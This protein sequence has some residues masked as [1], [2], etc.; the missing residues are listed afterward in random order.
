MSN[1]EFDYNN[2]INNLDSQAKEY[3]NNEIKD[4]S[5]R[6]YL[7][8]R[9]NELSTIY[10]KSLISINKADT[11]RIKFLTQLF[12]E[13]LYHTSIDCNKSEIPREHW[14]EIL[15]N[16]SACIFEETKKSIKRNWSYS[17]TLDSV[18]KSLEK[19]WLQIIDKLYNNKKINKDIRD[20]AK[21]QSN[22]KEMRANYLNIQYE[23]SSSIP[24]DKKS[25]VNNKIY[26]IIWII[27]LLSLVI[28]Y[29]FLPE[30]RSVYSSLFHLLVTI[31]IL[32]SI[33]KFIKKCITKFKLKKKNNEINKLIDA[34]NMYSKLSNDIITIHLGLSLED[35]ANPDKEGTLLLQIQAKRI[36]LVYELGYILPYTRTIT[37]NSLE[38]NQYT[39]C[40]RDKEVFKDSIDSDTNIA[41]KI[42]II[43]N[44]LEQIVLKHADKIISLSDIR[45]YIEVVNKNNKELVSNLVPKHLSETD[46][47][48]IFISLIKQNISIR[49]IVW[50]FELLNDYGPSTKNIDELIEKLKENL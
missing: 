40:L 15:Q 49:N 47:K 21:N 39:I 42:E 50:V 19:S 13:F 27:I 9:I 28:L 2:F 16:I 11:E 5:N 48:R 25:E 46:I 23:S 24:I 33:I 29:C 10:I 1:N 38:A 43:V 37:D 22:I 35:I 30:L 12:Y 17:E 44:N 4:S 36:K 7:F 8:C 34:N 3:L 20:K 31:F 18:E 26:Y 6:E 41:K 45:K 32:T 14:S